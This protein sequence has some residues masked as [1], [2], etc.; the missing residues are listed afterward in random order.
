MLVK[1]SNLRRASYR[2]I[3]DQILWNIFGVITFIQS[4][5]NS[6]FSAPP[7]EIFLFNDF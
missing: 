5:K 3:W 1:P 4:P 6:A 7:R 2:K